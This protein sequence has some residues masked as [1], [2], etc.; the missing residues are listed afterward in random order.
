MSE[1]DLAAILVRLD[2]IERRLKILEAQTN[3]QVLQP[4]AGK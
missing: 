3:L 4:G 2:D 1:I